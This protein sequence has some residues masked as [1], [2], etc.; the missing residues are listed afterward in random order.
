M[1]ERL[2]RRQATELTVCCAYYSA[3]ARIIATAG[4]ELEDVSPIAA[5]TAERPPPPAP[6][7]P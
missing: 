4:V 7:T 1:L 5:I 2:G 3:V 6:R